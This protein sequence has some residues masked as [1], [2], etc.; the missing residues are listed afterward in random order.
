LATTN[1]NV[2]TG[3]AGVHVDIPQNA[4]CEITT[5]SAFS[6]G[7]FDGFNKLNDGRYETPGFSAAKNK[8]YIH[9]SGGFSGFEVKRY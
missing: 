2:S 8:I 7:D 5:S 3:M 1:V 4:A 9:L 6:S